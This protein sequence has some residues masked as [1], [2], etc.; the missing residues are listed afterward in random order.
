MNNEIPVEIGTQ[1]VKKE[2]LGI[3]KIVLTII[4]GILAIEVFR[5]AISIA[6]QARYGI[7]TDTSA[8]GKAQFSFIIV[9]TLILSSFVGGFLAGCITKKKGWLFGILLPIIPNAL[10][11]IF[12]S[13][14]LM[15]RELTPS[16]QI[17]LKQTIFDN[18]I[19]FAIQLL[20][21][22]L[23]GILGEKMAKS[24]SEEILYREKYE[25]SDNKIGILNYYFALK[26]RLLFT[27]PFLALCS[28]LFIY[29]LGDALLLIKWAVIGP[30][31][32]LIHPSLWLFWY[33]VPI[34]EILFGLLFTAVVIPLYAP[35]WAYIIAAR[36][37]AR[38]KRNLKLIGFVLAITLGTFLASSLGHLPILWSLNKITSEGTEV[39]PI[40]L[41]KET[42]PK[43]YH[44]LAVFYKEEGKE[45]KSEKEFEKAYVAYCKLGEYLLNRKYYLNAINAYS[46]AVSIYSDKIEPHYKLGIAYY[47]ADEYDLAIGEFNKVL[48]T[49]PKN[50]AA[51]V[52]LALA[53]E[54]KYKNKDSALDQWRKCL[55]T[56][57]SS[58]IP[59]EIKSWIHNYIFDPTQA[60]LTAGM[61]A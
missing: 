9:S 5:Y 25:N 60:V 47:M 51:N 45:E 31:Y 46:A 53:Y 58:T 30:V 7:D 37:E 16:G 44:R 8:L 49:Q 12:I 32:I 19:W 24:E 14:S 38:V 17:W 54:K 11:A 23:G 36:Q 52:N 59:E 18:G 61:E 22:L 50:F 34:W 3:G 33:I 39:W 6:L 28:Y 21:C 56:T 13:V 2:R 26:W 15:M 42:A 27:I 20:P 10:L 40:L 4:S 41:D 29:Y 57:D 43:T 55:E 48:A 1:V 35:I